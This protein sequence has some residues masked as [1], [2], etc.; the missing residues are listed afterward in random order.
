MIGQSE[1]IRINSGQAIGG[2]FKVNEKKYIN[3]KSRFCNEVPS[4]SFSQ[5]LKEFVLKKVGCQLWIWD[6]DTKLSSCK[7]IA[8]FMAYKNLMKW[9]TASKLS[10]LIEKTQ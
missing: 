7:D 5:C 4:Y 10:D 3:K 6:D 8:D 2:D 1:R 9:I